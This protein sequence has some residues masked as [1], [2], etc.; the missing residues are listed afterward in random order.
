MVQAHRQGMDVKLGNDIK[1]RLANGKDQSDEV[2]RLVIKSLDTGR[3]YSNIN[4]RGP[5]RNRN[6]AT[7]GYL[8]SGQ[9]KSHR[10]HHLNILGSSH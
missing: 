5:Y 8:L 10:Q 9:I 6:F 4:T 7:K 1:G 2:I 3:L